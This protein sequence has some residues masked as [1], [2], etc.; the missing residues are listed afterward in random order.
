MR[1]LTVALV[2]I[3]M[4]TSAIAQG[5]GAGPDRP[6][7]QIG[8]GVAHL[9]MMELDISVGGIRRSPELR[10][11]V[12]WSSRFALETIVMVSQRH[13]AAHYGEA[14]VRSTHTQGLYA[15]QIRQRLMD[16]SRGRFESFATYGAAGYY[17]FI[18]DA[19]E[20]ALTF[21]DGQTVFVRDRYRVN[22]PP[23]A[24]V[25]GVGVQHHLGRRIAVRAD[26]QILAALVIPFGVR[27][28]A[29]L[30]IPFGPYP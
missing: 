30:S 19:P 9:S 16:G 26:L 10:L 15:F 24:T 21:S 23:I 25:V 4:P 14:T 8:V 6:P 27:A 28:S 22:I 29:G 2:T 7:I 12:P 20:T 13:R 11:T 5:T 3:L 1:Y 18:T 17:D